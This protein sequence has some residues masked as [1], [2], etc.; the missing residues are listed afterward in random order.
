MIYYHLDLY[1]DFDKKIE[2]KFNSVNYG[3]WLLTVGVG[4][5]N[6]FVCRYL[7]D[8]NGGKIL[9]PRKSIPS[10]ANETLATCRYR[11]RCLKHD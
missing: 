2:K 7:Q 10:E 11:Y 8:S 9:P 3:R 4:I 6:M 1:K 5:Q